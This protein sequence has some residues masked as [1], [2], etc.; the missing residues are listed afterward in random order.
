LSCP[1]SS[2]AVSKASDNKV[3]A[4]GQVFLVGAGPGDPGLITCRGAELLQK[5]EA[6]LYDSL[7]NPAL[8]QLAPPE[9]QLEPVGKRAGEPSWTQP[10]I[11]ARLVELARSGLRVVRLKGGDTSI[12]ARTAEEIESLIAA[13]L[14]FEV[15]PGVT[16]ASAVASHAGVPLTHRDWSS[17]VAFVSG[18]PQ[19]AEGGDEAA[20]QFDWEA[21]ARFPGTLVIYMGGRTAGLWSRGLMAGGLAS[22]TPVALLRRCSWPDQQARYCTLETVGESLAF[23]GGFEPPL[24]AVV[25]PVASRIH[26]NGWL[27]T[28]PL[29]G[30]SVLITRPLDKSDALLDC[31]RQA[32]AQV[33]W[34]PSL[35]I[36]PP[37]DLQPLD[38]AAADL[39]QY[40]WLLL[41]SRQAIDP[42]L[43]SL[44]RQGW[45]A[46]RLAGL[47][48]AV[49]GPGTAE[50]L[51]ERGL[52]ADLM[53]PH[54]HR[55]TSLAQLLEPQV[56][57]QRCLWPCGVAAG[58]E[59]VE[60]LQRAGAQVDRVVAYQ[61]APISELDPKIIAQFER[62]QI[63]W[64]SVCSSATADALHE[65]LGPTVL[66]RCRL[67]SFSPTITRR[68]EQL[69]YR[70]AAE[71][72]ETRPAAL[73]EAIVGASSEQ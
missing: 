21:L 52:R 39:D 37:D 29:L 22:S 23:G 2:G 40:H 1:S 68:L 14:A 4:A 25:G 71:S 26:L 54:P 45:D 3:A 33:G 63:D 51:A 15:V 12:F 69:G 24:L 16:A 35:R 64:V 32:G 28:R 57:G 58:P 43:K 27:A 11:N 66:K 44:W 55:A 20:E 8:L 9:A 70:V 18:A 62:G 34:L 53:A 17:A 41:T 72:A 47:R 42:L 5:A 6:V 10:Q 65:M 38:R 7:I 59:L 67:A 73:V 49:V 13:G 48:I 60:R 19:G 50:R 46:R 36:E 30:Q 56:A 61:A 31:L